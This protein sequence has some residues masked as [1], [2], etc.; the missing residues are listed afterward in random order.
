MIGVYPLACPLSSLRSSPIT[1]EQLSSSMSDPTFLLRLTMAACKGQV[2]DGELRGL[3]EAFKSSVREG[4]V[5]SETMQQRALD[6]L[7]WVGLVHV[8]DGELGAI[9]FS[10]LCGAVGQLLLSLLHACYVKGSR[11]LAHKCSR[12]L[13]ILYR[14]GCV[15]VRMCVC[16]CM[17]VCA[18]MCVCT[19]MCV[20][21]HVCA[22]MC[23]FMCVYVCE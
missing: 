20:C 22:C 21:M 12:L 10:V 2:E 5:F 13:V 19:C 4:N 11:M 9:G 8:Q 15:D 6:V 3:P 18:C 16:V 1:V 17:H 7:L 14:Y 23:V